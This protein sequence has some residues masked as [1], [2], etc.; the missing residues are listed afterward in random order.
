MRVMEKKG[1]FVRPQLKLENTN[2]N[3]IIILKYGNEVYKFK[4]HQKIGKLNKTHKN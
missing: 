3:R 1:C 2:D 4:E